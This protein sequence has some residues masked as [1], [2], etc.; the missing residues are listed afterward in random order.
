MRAA[1]RSIDAEIREETPPRQE[2]EGPPETSYV[3]R[4]SFLTRATLA[5][6]AVTSSGVFAL[7]AEADNRQQP[8]RQSASMAAIA[9]ALDVATAINMVREGAGL[10]A[11]AISEKLTA[12]AFAHVMDLAANRTDRSCGGNLHSWSGRRHRGRGGCYSNADESTW[13]LMWE[14]PRVIAGYPSEG[15]EIAYWSSRPVVPGMAIESW[16]ASPGH[17]DVILNAGEWAS[18]TWRALGA[19]HAG[20][21]ACAWFGTVI[22]P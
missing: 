13:P 8:S 9:R 14:K 2:G 5:A 21:Y 16:L 11:I 20:G 15:Y 10:P 22:D 7:G 4:R 3:S 1:Q 6:G 18:Y 19:F 17:R 12:V